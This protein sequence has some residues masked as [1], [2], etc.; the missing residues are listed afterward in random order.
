MDTLTFNTLAIL[1]ASDAGRD[2]RR[3]G[4]PLIG[5]PA[6]TW[7]ALAGLGL[8]SQLGAYYALVHA[9]GH[10]PATVTSVS[11]LAQVPGTAI[12][13]MLLLGEPLSRRSD[14]GHRDRARRHLHREQN[15]DDELHRLTAWRPFDPERCNACESQPCGFSGSLSEAHGALRVYGPSRIGSRPATCPRW[16]PPDGVRRACAWTRRSS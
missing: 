13:A 12:L 7:L 1:A 9:L 4:I 5:Y 15:G 2:L 8:I 10:L 16:I 6:R 14:C 3:L 11:L